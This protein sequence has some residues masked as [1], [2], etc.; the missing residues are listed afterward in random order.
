MTET[1]S[2][3]VEAAAAKASLGWRLERGTA[4]SIVLVDGAGRRHDGGD[5]EACGCESR[6]GGSQAAGSGSHGASS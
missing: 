4:G 6:D 2:T 1:R 3:D 5:H